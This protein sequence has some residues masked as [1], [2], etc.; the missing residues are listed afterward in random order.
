MFSTVLVVI[1]LIGL[2]GLA[3]KRRVVVVILVEQVDS[4]RSH[5]AHFQHPARRELVLNAEIVLPDH[6]R[7]Q[8]FIQERHV[9]A[10]GLARWRSSPNA[11]RTSRAPEWTGTD[12]PASD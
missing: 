3:S 12:S 10:G 11:K 1:P 2:L 5:V 7:V 4:A 8:N 6:R 9:Q